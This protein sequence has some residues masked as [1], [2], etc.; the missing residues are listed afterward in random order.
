MRR[1]AVVGNH[2]PRQCGIATFTA[3]LIA[4]VSSRF[5]EID[6]F[7]VAMNDRP[8]GYAYPPVVRFAI[9]AGDPGSYRRVA[10]TLNASNVDVV[11]L[12]HEYGIFG[13][14][15]GSHLL[16]LLET[17]DVPLVTTL[18]T[19]LQNPDDA[20]CALMAELT[21]LSA[22]L[23]V[24]S[25]RG[26]QILQDV[27]GV[28]PAK[29]VVIHH[30]IPSLPTGDGA[31]Q[32]RALGLAGRSVLLTFGLLSPDKGI[33][34]VIAAMPEI[35]Q[36]FPDT[37][38]V[39]LGAT[40]PH[41]LQ[42]QGETYRE[43][44]EALAKRL[45]VEK[46]VEFHNHFVPTEVLTQFLSAADIYITPYLK[47]E[48]ITSGT[49]A[50]AVGSGKA[51]ISTPYHYAEELLAD[52]RGVLVP[53]R[54]P[55]AIAREVSGLL[56]DPA[57]R[58]EIQNQ[59]RALG[60]QMTWHAVAEGYGAT[61]LQARAGHE[62]N[63][64]QK[65]DDTG[66]FRLATNDA[67]GGYYLDDNAR[68]L[69]RMMHQRDRSVEE[70]AWTTRYLEFARQ[71]LHMGTGYFRDF[72]SGDHVWGE[73]VVEESHGRTLWALGSVVERSGNPVWRGLA[74]Q[75]FHAALPAVEGFTSPRAWAYTLLGIDEILRT[76]STSSSIEA[77]RTVL[78]ERLLRQ[79][80]RD[81]A[82][83]V[84]VRF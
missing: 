15:A 12:Q 64:P 33:E 71:S 23:V 6:C 74:R 25:Q 62:R 17:L 40:H 81:K 72:L 3:D 44:L 45:G 47:P 46:N 32:K 21:R 2:T 36:K 58:E 14:E 80:P 1:I 24:M 37:V 26:A 7:A 57:R 34:N 49:L 75:L 66:L 63:L 38:Y 4:A 31:Q 20:Q 13:G 69:L 59:A 60:R 35:L 65:A 9:D 67:P 39:V 73:P 43:S 22:R 76:P 55:Q 53:W 42:S 18:H 56:G 79:L 30:G 8:E 28:D 27:H 77:L 51:V 50:Y 48:Q 83:G 82:S 70:A 16:A 10:K 52:G 84:P 11:C 41:L 68:A 19:I 78:T 5:P 54:D 29:I 61:L